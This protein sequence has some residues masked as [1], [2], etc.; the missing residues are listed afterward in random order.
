MMIVITRYFTIN[1][2]DKF[3][4]KSNHHS[5]N[6]NEH[7]RSINFEEDKHKIL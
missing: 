5:Q 1:Y 2:L 7:K 3:D 4:N 6:G